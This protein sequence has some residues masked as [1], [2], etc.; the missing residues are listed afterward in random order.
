MVGEEGRRTN[1]GRQSV[2]GTAAE[3]HTGASHGFVF[4]NAN[5][6]C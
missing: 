4:F 2:D 3:V 6:E 5:Q 1:G